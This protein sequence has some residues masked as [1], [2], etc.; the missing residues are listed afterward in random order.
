MDI[1]IHGHTQKHR[2]T[3]ALNSSTQPPPSPRPLHSDRPAF[4][5]THTRIH[6]LTHRLTH[7]LTHL[8][9]PQACLFHSCPSQ[10]SV[11]ALTF[12]NIPRLLPFL[13]SQ[14]LRCFLL[15]TLM[16]RETEALRAIP[17]AELQPSPGG[18]VGGFS[19][20]PPL[21]ELN[22]VP[23]CAA[24]PSSPVPRKYRPRAPAELVRA[25]PGAQAPTGEERGVHWALTQLGGGSCPV[26]PSPRAGHCRWPQGTGPGQ[27][28]SPAL[29]VTQQHQPF[30][31]L[32]GASRA[33]LDDRRIRE[34]VGW[35]F[36][37][38]SFRAWHPG[39]LTSSVR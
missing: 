9:Q 13:S 36:P 14:D 2:Y 22:P 8:Q 5:P 28:M 12:R 6:T 7:T 29:N 1:Q 10:T 27:P 32:S 26:T 17:C 16:G 37:L 38:Q 23:P 15:P 18:G 3:D 4:T 33:G 35:A 31:P 11:P 19:H 25:L 34:G 21:P 30:C 39:T 20:L 24:S